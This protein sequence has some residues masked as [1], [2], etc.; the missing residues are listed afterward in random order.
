MDTTEIDQ[1]NT[2]KKK[3]QNSKLAPYCLC[4][5]VLLYDP[6]PDK[7][8]QMG[9]VDKVVWQWG[10]GVCN[11]PGWT[12]QVV[13]VH[14]WPSVSIKRK[15]FAPVEWTS[16]TRNPS[17]WTFGLIAALERCAYQG[18]PVV[19]VF[20]IRHVHVY[21]C[22]LTYPIKSHIDRSKVFSLLDYW[23]VF[24]ISIWLWFSLLGKYMFIS[25]IYK[26]KYTCI[27]LFPKFKCIGWLV[28][29][30]SGSSS[31]WPGLFSSPWGI[32]QESYPQAFSCL[33]L[34]SS[35]FILSNIFHFKYGE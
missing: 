35:S 2:K 13:L 16:K 6:D 18:A 20:S 9:F 25:F 4:Y 14:C 23:K 8:Q 5:I 22:L 26:Y 7:T 19:Y 17:F 28:W 15:L 29:L 12:L 30:F 1:L 24:G 11:S 10:V 21:H 32:W 33:C 3:Q 27:K 31:L 34:S